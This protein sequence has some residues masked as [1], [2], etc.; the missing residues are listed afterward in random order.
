MRRACLIG[1][2]TVQCGTQWAPHWK[3][4][5]GEK[6]SAALSGG[7]AGAGVHVMKL[8]AVSHGVVA[9]A[10]RFNRLGGRCAHVLDQRDTK[11]DPVRNET[12]LHGRYTYVL[13]R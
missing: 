12:W 1:T 3:I 10:L 2:S 5:C 7:C 13:Y 9:W 11:R 4:H 6:K 8:Q